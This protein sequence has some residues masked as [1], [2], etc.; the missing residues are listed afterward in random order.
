[1]PSGAVTSDCTEYL[2]VNEKEK[3][4]K[5]LQ[6]LHYQRNEVQCDGE[7]LQLPVQSQPPTD[8]S[9]HNLVQVCG[10]EKEE[11]E[12]GDVFLLCLSGLYIYI[13]KEINTIMEVL[14]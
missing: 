6:L 7:Q 4:C 2:A 14:S 9:L 8:K 5:D 3:L 1:M 11:L 12:E 10:P 13:S